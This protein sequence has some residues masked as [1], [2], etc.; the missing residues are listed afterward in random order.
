MDLFIYLFI[1]LRETGNMHK[2]LKVLDV[3]YMYIT[4]LCFRW[5]ML[6]NVISFAL[7]NY[8]FFVYII[9]IVILNDIQ[10]PFGLNGSLYIFVLIETNVMFVIS[11][12]F[13]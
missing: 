9:Y 12:W 4:A 3:Q 10:I 2:K 11:A 7:N 5:S 6:L 8:F 13:S 1:S